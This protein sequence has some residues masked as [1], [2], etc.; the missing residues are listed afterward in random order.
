MTS[1]GHPDFDFEGGERLVEYW[2][3]MRIRLTIS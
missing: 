3:G 2:P 1:F